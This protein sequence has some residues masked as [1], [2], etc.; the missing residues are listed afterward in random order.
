MSTR[1]P[2]AYSRVYSRAEDLSDAIIHIS[3]ITAALIGGP[4]LITLAAIWFGSW[5]VV[6]ATTVYVVCLVLMLT[7][8][9]LY[10]MVNRPG[11]KDCLRR[12]DQSAIYMKIAGTYTPFVALAGT[13]A[14]WF[15]AGIWSVAIGGASLILFA[16][17]RFRLIAIV[18]YLALGWAG[19][20]W[21]GPLVSNLSAGGSILLLIGGCL[22]TAGVAFLLWER[23]PFHNTIW[24]VFVLAGTAVC[25]AALVVELSGHA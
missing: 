6:T 18:L 20:F 12:I 10:N 25:Y 17:A 4:I 9:A 22:Y 23:L 16:P 24:H 15:L 14:G 11:L 8:S 13:H 2:A 21:G 19:V 7:C 3:G 5:S 1:I